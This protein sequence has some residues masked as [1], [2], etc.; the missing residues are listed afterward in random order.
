[1]SA[2]VE[3]SVIILGIG[4]E[5]SVAWSGRSYDITI[6]GLASSR[7]KERKEAI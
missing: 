2:E 5:N 6:G 4:H 3:E 7:Q 1:M